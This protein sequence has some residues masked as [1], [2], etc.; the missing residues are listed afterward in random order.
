MEGGVLLLL[1]SNPTACV[2]QVPCRNYPI[3]LHEPLLAGGPNIASPL[4]NGCTQP[5]PCLMALVTMQA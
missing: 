1:F 5:G 4:R 3:A 2:P